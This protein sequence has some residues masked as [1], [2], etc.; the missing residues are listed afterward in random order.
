MTPHLPH[1]SFTKIKEL[2]HS[3]RALRA[4][5]EGAKETTD[6]MT[7]GN[8]LDCLL[9]EPHLLEERFLITE[10]FDRRSKAAK[11]KWAA[12]EESAKANKQ[13]LIFDTDLKDAEKEANAVRYNPTVQYLGLLAPECQYQP[14]V[15]FKYRGWQHKGRL[16]ILKPRK[17]IADLK[18]VASCVPSILKKQ[19]I[20]D[21]KYHL[22][23]AIYREGISQQ[24]GDG[25]TL[26]YYIIAVDAK[27]EC[28]VFELQE[29][30]LNRGVDL[31]HQALAALTKE[32]NMSSLWG[33]EEQYFTEFLGK[34]QEYWADNKNEGTFYL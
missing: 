33:D 23:A 22:Q 9:F 29:E 20:W 17:L 26:P 7:A 32:V 2:L 27:C 31:W 16:D 13:T 34:G 28:V 11:A 4:Y 5:M 15:D 3:P 6:A 12:L 8:L 1:L 24:S 19:L 18:R 30:T 14:A 21:R 10:K 25:R